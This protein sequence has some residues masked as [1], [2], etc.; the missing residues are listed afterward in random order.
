MSEN[1]EDIQYESEDDSIDG[2]G[3][4]SKEIKLREKLKECEEKRKEYLTGWQRAKADLINVRRRQEEDKGN[5]ILRANSKLIQDV[6]P[7]LDSFEVAMK[8]RQVWEQVDE[9]WRSGIESIYKQLQS[10]LKDHGVK[11][12]TPSAGDE[13]NTDTQEAV[14]SVSTDQAERDKMVAELIQKGYTLH[15]QIIRPARVKVFS[16]EE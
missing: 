4:S 11:T 9:T 3:R 13:F 15:G 1:N 14:G 6:I 2:F 12:I 8:N 10:V 5:I 7:V 16:Y